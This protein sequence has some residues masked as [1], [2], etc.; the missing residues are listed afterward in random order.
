MDRDSAALSMAPRRSNPAAGPIDRDLGR[1]GGSLGGF[2]NDACIE[3]GG[4]GTF[5]GVSW[6]SKNSRNTSKEP[7]GSLL[8]VSWELLGAPLV[9]LWCPSNPQN[10]KSDVN[11][12]FD[13][14]LNS[15]LAFGSPKT[16]SHLAFGAPTNH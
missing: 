4:L 7:R 10:F 6:T 8:E 3:D 13:A 12:R 2:E 11:N 14:N 16:I 15:Q 5:L 1:P 9:P